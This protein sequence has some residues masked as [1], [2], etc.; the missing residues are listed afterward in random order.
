[1]ED[2][3]MHEMTRAVRS[4]LIGLGRFARRDLR[5]SGA[6]ALCARRFVFLL[7]GVGLKMSESSPELSH[8][9][10][11][12][13]LKS[14]RAGFVLAPAFVQQTHNVLVSLGADSPEAVLGLTWVWARTLF[15]RP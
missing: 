14:R 12:A 10:L 9:D 5:A 6:S 4:T 1:M 3:H 8:F 11:M 13:F 2:A 15:C 7:S